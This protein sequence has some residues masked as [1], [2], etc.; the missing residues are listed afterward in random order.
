MGYVYILTDKSDDIIK[1]VGVVYGINNTLEAEIEELSNESWYLSS[2]FEIKYI[3]ADIQ[4]QTDAVLLESHYIAAFGTDKYY[5]ADKK[6]CERSSYL[7]YRNDWRKFKPESA[8]TKSISQMISE[9]QM[10]IVELRK[11]LN[12]ETFNEKNKNGF[13]YRCVHCDYKRQYDQLQ[14]AQYS[15]LCIDEDNQCLTAEEIILLYK[16]GTAVN[17]ISEVYD[18][19]GHLVCKKHMYTDASGM[20]NFE[21]SRVIRDRY[22]HDYKGTLLYS[23]TDTRMH[24]YEVFKI[25]RNIGNHLFHPITPQQ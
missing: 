25:F 1:Y 22:S 11:Q 18:Y 5:N 12:A 15:D 14:T 23:P 20:L 10:E 2:Q 8:S 21:G 17:Y 16:N 3:K 24:S 4:S 9:L 6:G 19:Q 13:P 7:P